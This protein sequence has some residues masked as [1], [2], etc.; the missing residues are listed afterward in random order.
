MKKL[1]ALLLGCLITCGALAE[2]APS[3]ADQKWLQAVEKIIAKGEKQVST[4]SESRV[5]L[6]KDWAEKKGY[7]VKVTKVE[8]NFRVEVSSKKSSENVA[9]K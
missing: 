5:T 4:P 3:E 6:L 2:G 1:T 7:S 8:Q 9:Q